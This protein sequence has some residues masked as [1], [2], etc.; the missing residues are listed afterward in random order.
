MERE[1][2]ITKTLKRYERQLKFL[3]FGGLSA[4]IE[5]VAFL[6]VYNFVDIYWSALISFMC[7][8]VFSF[9]FNKLIVFES[10]CEV[11][12]A[13]GRE[14]MSFLVLGLI[15]SQISSL[16]TLGLSQ[17]TPSVAAKI[18]TMA[19]VAVW[20]YLIMSKIIFKSKNSIS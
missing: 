12:R 5:F 14:I 8:L 2:R 15:N 19:M 9:I 17:L 3:F 6:I 20:N 18:I 16:V 4:L 1:S 10:K 13:V 7:G 11:G